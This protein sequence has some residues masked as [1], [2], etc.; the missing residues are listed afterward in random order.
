VECCWSDNGSTKT[1][2]FPPEIL[3]KAPDETVTLADKTFAQLY[4][5]KKKEDAK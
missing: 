1:G 5:N 4:A 3:E 2:N